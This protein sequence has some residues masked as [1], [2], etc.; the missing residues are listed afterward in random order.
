MRIQSNFDSVKTWTP[1]EDAVLRR[2][3]ALRSARE[4]GEMLG[5]ARNAVI[6]RA[7]RIG[8][9]V[10]EAAL[11]NRLVQSA[12]TRRARRPKFTPANVPALA[13]RTAA[14]RRRSAPKPPAPLSERTSDT[15]SF[16]SQAKAF[17]RWRD[18]VAL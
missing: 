2:E 9:A 3:Y 17:L 8:L 15:S 1:D 10:P 7:R 6:G 5:R 12:K 4:L 13:L 11:H 14:K 18:E 16:R